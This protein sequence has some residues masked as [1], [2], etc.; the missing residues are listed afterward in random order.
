MNRLNALGNFA[1]KDIGEEKIL[2]KKDSS[3]CPVFLNQFKYTNGKLNLF[4]WV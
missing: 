4:C 1:I 2:K 3:I